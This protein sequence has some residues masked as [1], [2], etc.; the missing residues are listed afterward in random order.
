MFSRL[1]PPVRG[2]VL[3]MDGVLW[4]DTAPIGNLALVFGRMQ[5]AGLTVMLAT[6]N[7]TMTVEQYL[8]RLTGFGVHLDAWQI[9][10]SANALAAILTKEYPQKGAVYV[11]GEEGVVAALCEAGFAAITDPD[12]EAQAIAVVAG[13]DRSL[14]YGKL[15]RAMFNIRAGARFYGTNPDPT[16]PTPLGPVPG[17][18]SVLAAIQTA[19]GTKPI[20]IGKP[21]PYMFTLCAERMQLDVEELLVVGDRLETDIAGGQAVG[22]RTALVLSGI[23]SQAQADQWLPR[24]DLIAQ[25]L[26]ELVSA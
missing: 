26:T 21:S 22:A 9:I 10:T 17:A 24:P 18:G 11:V 12:D 6:N 20:V 15:R 2:I 16:F 7:G 1:T 25:D 5:A 3:D 14:S 13:L 4:K 8:K 23:S 19:S